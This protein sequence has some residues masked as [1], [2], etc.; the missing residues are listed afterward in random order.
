MKLENLCDI[1]LLSTNFTNCLRKDGDGKEDGL[2]PN[3]DTAKRGARLGQDPRR[4]GT[5]LSDSEIKK[6]IA[7]I[8]SEITRLAG[9]TRNIA[10]CDAVTLIEKKIKAS[11]FEVRYGIS[12]ISLVEDLVKEA[13]KVRQTASTS[14][15]T[16][17]PTPPKPTTTTTTPRP[18]TT[19]TTT[20]P[21]PRPTTTTTTRPT[22]RP[23]PRT[24]TRGYTPDFFLGTWMIIAVG[25]VGACIIA[26]IITGLIPGATET[27]SWFLGLAVGGFILLASVCAAVRGYDGGLGYWYPDWYDW[28]NEHVSIIIPLTGMVATVLLFVLGLIPAAIIT[29]VL[30]LPA[31]FVSS[32]PD[33]DYYRADGVD[34]AYPLTYVLATVGAVCIGIFCDNDGLIWIA[35]AAAAVILVVLSLMQQHNNTAIKEEWYFPF[36]YLPAYF[37]AA[38]GFVDFHAGQRVAIMTLGAAVAWVLIASAINTKLFM[39]TDETYTAETFYNLSP[40]IMGIGGFVVSLGLTILGAVS[41]ELL[42]F[43]MFAV[44]VIFGNMI[45]SAITL[46]GEEGDAMSATSVVFS[47]FLSIANMY[48]IASYEDQGD[49]LLWTTI[50]AML[51]FAYACWRIN[52]MVSGDVNNSELFD[53]DFY[54]HGNEAVV[55]FTIIVDI[56]MAILLFFADMLIYAAIPV[57]I[58][59]CA[60][61]F[62]L[63]SFD[64][65]LET[66]LISGSMT[67]SIVAGIFFLIAPFVFL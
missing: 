30:S 39:V 34:Y 13:K 12:N 33:D 41:E 58:V 60:V 42:I 45:S 65:D 32:L 5:K 43:N 18:T 29:L 56:A 15:T 16:T 59:F 57:G 36:L 31:S 4:N 9:A 3:K 24:K 7:E 2:I 44:L 28:Y 46:A 53:F 10:F 8:E 64:D 35:F 17:T 52:G 19:T 38:N 51:F 47:S 26:S 49:F 63:L 37:L 6:Q 62:I 54:Y 20:R 61:N 50:V 22:P 27:F 21:T 11:P 23:T 48:F 1:I 66:E 67:V 40:Y 14:T 55:I 25:V